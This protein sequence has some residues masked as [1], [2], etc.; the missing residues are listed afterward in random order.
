MLKA[1]TG[2]LTSSRKLPIERLKVLSASVRALASRVM[3]SGAELG[4]PEAILLVEMLCAV[5]ATDVSIMERFLAGQSYVQLSTFDF[6][7]QLK[8]QIAPFFNLETFFV[9]DRTPSKESPFAIFAMGNKWRNDYEGLDFLAI[10]EAIS[11][12]SVSS[13]D[14]VS[15]DD[16]RLILLIGIER[17]NVQELDVVTIEILRTFA[18]AIERDFQWLGD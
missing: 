5:D 13:R 10:S 8:K 17:L 6:A 15:L 3:E 12:N 16:G 2:D 1:L 9:M 4:H 14:Y 7:N 18:S 11:K